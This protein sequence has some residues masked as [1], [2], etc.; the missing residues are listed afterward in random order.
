MSIGKSDGHNDPEVKKVEE[1]VIRTA[2]EMGVT[3]RAEVSTPDQAKRYAD[4]GVRHFSI[5]TDLQILYDW[6]RD[7]GAAL[8]EVI[9]GA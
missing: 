6:W 9:S 8:R 1:Y 2:L 4:M 7:N 3:P 5:G